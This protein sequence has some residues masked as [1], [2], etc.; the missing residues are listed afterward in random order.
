M[1]FPKEVIRYRLGVQSLI[2]H[3]WAEGTDLYKTAGTTDYAPRVADHPGPALIDDRIY[4]FHWT[5]DGD[6]IQSSHPH[7]GRL[8]LYGPTD[9]LETEAVLLRE[10]EKA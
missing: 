5:E 6:L 4:E 2:L 9:D 8:G 7:A 3:D 10:V 1:T